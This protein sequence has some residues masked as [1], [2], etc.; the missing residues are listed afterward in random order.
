MRR[1]IL[2]ITACLTLILPGLASVPA[3]A[4]TLPPTTK[5]SNPTNSG[6][7]LEIAPPVITLTANPGQTLKV[8]IFLRDISSSNLIVTSQA[9]DFVAAGEDG[10]PK[11]LLNKESN[12]PYS[13]RDWVVPPAS[14]SLVPREIKSLTVT[15]N[16][17]ANASP[18]GHYGIIRF[19]GTAPSLQGTGV[20]L[21]A[22]LGS[23]ILLTV[24]GQVNENLSVKEFSVNHNGKTGT[25]FQSGPVN[26]VVRLLNNGNVHE[27]PVGQITIKDMFGKKF[28]A[29]NV[30]LPPKN[31]LPSSTRKFGIP[32]DSS[33]IGN[34]K[35]L[36]RYTATLSVTYG[37]DKK[38]LTSSTTFWVIPYSLLAIIIIGL[39]A[40]FFVLRFALR[41]YNRYILNRSNRPHHK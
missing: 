18:G 40:L 30:N 4:A 24:N 9:N 6:Q 8:Q 36:G 27:Q 10:T 38:V 33:V 31:V 22:S 37:K 7:A 39:I 12:N 3:W 20:S 25:V 1:F 28:A 14:L 15:I 23:L 17:P 11:V 21:S 41:R 13:L 5:T 26:F 16:V 2:L 35:L 34:K 19:T 29:V 32:L